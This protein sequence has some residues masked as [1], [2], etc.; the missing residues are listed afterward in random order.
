MPFV[1]VDGVRFHYQQTGSGPDVVLLHAVTSN[2]AVWL[3]TGLPDAL[4]GEFRVTAYDFRGHGASDVTPAG[5]TSAAMADDYRRLHA[6]LGLGPALLV[7][8]S[9]GAVVATHAAVLH[10][11][12]VRGLVLSDPYFPGLGHVEPHLGQAD[13]WR[14]VKDA[15]A[16]AGAELGEG[17]DFA[18]L[19]RQVAGLTPEQK[20]A[21]KTTLGP[22]AMRWLSQLPRLAET[23]CGRD[24]F[25]PA[26]LDAAALAGVRQPV[27]ALYDEF[28]S[29]SATRRYLAENLPRW[30]IDTVPG[31][32]HVAPLQNP[33]GFVQLVQKHLRALTA[34]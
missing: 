5:Y 18:R 6:A 22:S 26:G 14:E 28:T 9:F 31:A 30:V 29:F 34:G 3:F 17:V 20:E 33:A 19:F 16:G 10:P 8:H 13:V 25:E 15:L 4:A 21:V 27:V 7:G 1:S 2:L 12:T 24:V 32:R 23:T 11:S